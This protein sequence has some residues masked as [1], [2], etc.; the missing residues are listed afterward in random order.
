MR[1]ERPSRTTDLYCRGCVESCSFSHYEGS[2]KRDARRR[3]S[4]LS[5][6]AESH[7]TVLKVP[8]NGH[9]CLSVGRNHRQQQIAH[10]FDIFID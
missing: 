7:V 9:R 3:G 1:L 2:S 5:E 4:R 6:V 10:E 8:G